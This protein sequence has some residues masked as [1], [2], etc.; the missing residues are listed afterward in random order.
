MKQY[1][2]E[3]HDALNKYLLY[4]IVCNPNFSDEQ[5]AVINEALSA[6][7]GAGVV[8]GLAYA[9]VIEDKPLLSAQPIGEKGDPIINEILSLGIKYEPE[10]IDLT[11]EV[12]GSD[13]C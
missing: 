3:Y 6:A 2:K 1:P 8:S 10:I 5:L 9:S 11:K 7:H 4:P 13:I 12:M